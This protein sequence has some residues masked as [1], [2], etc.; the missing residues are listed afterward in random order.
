MPW[1]VPNCRKT[2]PE[3]GFSYLPTQMGMLVCLR[4]TISFP[5]SELKC[6]QTTQIKFAP[7]AFRNG[8]KD[9]D[10]EDPIFFLAKVCIGLWHSLL[11]AGREH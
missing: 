1:N 8:G 11:G 2:L 6:L 5:I 7:I 9:V 3:S 4:Q 10:E